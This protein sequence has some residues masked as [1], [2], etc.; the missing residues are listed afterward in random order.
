M[1]QVA[2]I[3]RPAEVHIVAALIGT[4][5]RLI[6]AFEDEA[7][8]ER[9]RNEANKYHQAKPPKPLWM[10]MTEAEVTRAR[11]PWDAWV[12]NHPAGDDHEACRGFVSH[13]VPWMGATGCASVS[14]DA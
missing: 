4:N 6:G 7:E 2:L 12:A 14:T 11:I 9:F 3:K 10:S 1:T 5:Q 8:A 13:A